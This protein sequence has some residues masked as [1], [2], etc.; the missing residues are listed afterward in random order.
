MDPIAARDFRLLVQELQAEGCTI[1]LTTHDMAE[2][3]AVCDRVALIDH[4]HLVAME[5]P[6][7]LSRLVAEHERIDFECDSDFVIQRVKRVIGVASVESKGEAAYRAHMSDNAAIPN[8]I[9]ILAEA[10]VSSVNTSRPNLEEVYVHII[11]DRGL[12]V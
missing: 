2:A 6:R 1:L 12:R 4:G 11:G 7:T 10:G 5:T 3:E 8:V 9:A